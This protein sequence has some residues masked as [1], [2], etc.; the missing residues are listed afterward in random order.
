[1]VDRIKDPIGW[2]YEEIQWRGMEGVFGQWLG[3]YRGEVIDVDDPEKRGRV[4]VRIPEM[5]AIIDGDVPL[6]YWAFVVVN[7]YVKKPQVEDK[8]GGGNE[9]KAVGRQVTGVWTNIEVG[10]LVMV[11][12]LGGDPRLPVVVGGWIPAQIGEGGSG[13]EKRYKVKGVDEFMVG[14]S[15][16]RGRGGARIKVDGEDIEIGAGK[17]G[18]VTDG[19]NDVKVYVKGEGAGREVVIKVGKDSTVTV[20]DDSIKVNK[21][22]NSIQVDSDSVDVVVGGSKIQV[23]KEGVKVE[24]VKIELEASEVVIGGDVVKLGKGPIYES[25]VL[26]DST[27]MVL[28]THTHVGNLG[29][30]TS[31][32]AMVLSKGAQLS[33]KIL[34]GK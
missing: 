27:A 34:V 9:A 10:D 24:G 28:Q 22:G 2:L 32:P 6:E 25:A 19:D 29:A 16:M 23:N 11:M 12:F 3:V 17:E 8:I 26:G 15:V 5:G 13:S 21:G 1:M 30:P 18:A 31:T 33:T 4:R 14:D 7:G 20:K